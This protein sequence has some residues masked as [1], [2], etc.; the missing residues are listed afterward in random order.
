MKHKDDYQ[1]IMLP[2]LS[3]FVV[4]MLLFE[5]LENIRP[6]NLHII[7]CSLDQYIPFLEVFSVPYLLWFFYI[8]ITA[9]VLWKVDFETFYRFCYTMM[10][11]MA[12]FIIVSYAYP[13]GLDIRPV[14]F[15]RENIFTDLTRFIYRID[16]STNVLPSIHVYNSVCAVFAIWESRY[17]E[18][19]MAVRKSA[20]V[21]TILIILSTMFLKQHSVF[22]VVLGLV[23]S[24]I[25]CEV[26]FHGFMVM[27]T[28]FEPIG[29]KWRKEYLNFRR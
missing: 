11:G 6:E 22:D 12:V 26:V 15:P 20:M 7:H 14:S 13:N 1:F 9:V 4:Y 3:F 25:A 24:C 5:H 16:T 23:I 8:G 29:T 18:K 21:L 2:I 10:F 28:R 17:F 27:G 19:K